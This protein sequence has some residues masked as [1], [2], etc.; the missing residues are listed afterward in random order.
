MLFRSFAVPEATASTARHIVASL[1]IGDHA[2]ANAQGQVPHVEERHLLRG[3][4]VF[5]TQAISDGKAR[6]EDLPIG[7]G[8]RL[9]DLWEVTTLSRYTAAKASKPRAFIANPGWLAKTMNGRKFGAVV[10]D[11]SH[12]ST[13]A[14]LAPLM[15]AASGCT[16]LRD[17]KSTRLNS[18]H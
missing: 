17:R 6:L 7:R 8:Q 5:V 14:Q 12:P 4:I 10:I 18:S 11:A 9:S 1:L 3:D 13:F 15:K 16:K 2:H